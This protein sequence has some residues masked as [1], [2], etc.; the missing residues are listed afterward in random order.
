VVLSASISLISS[1]CHDIGEEARL[2]QFTVPAGLEQ[3]HAKMGEPARSLAIPPPK[4]PDLA[5]MQTLADTYHFEIV[6]PPLRRGAS[7]R[8]S[9]AATSMLYSHTE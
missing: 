3:F 9:I 4:T 7:W 6:G 5:K 8:Y 1:A 2:L